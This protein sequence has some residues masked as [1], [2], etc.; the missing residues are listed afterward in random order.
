MSGLRGI[1]GQAQ[2]EDV[3]QEQYQQ[4]LQRRGGQQVCYFYGK[5]ADCQNIN[6]MFCSLCGKFLCD[7]CRADYP[8]RIAG[9]GREMANTVSHQFK[10]IFENFL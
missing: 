4:E 6:P 7:T 10:Q 5:Y 8:R 1:V 2:N 9:M 3:V